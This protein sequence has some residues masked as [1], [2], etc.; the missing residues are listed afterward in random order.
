MK[1]FNQNLL[2][3]KLTCKEVSEKITV[4]FG[5]FCRNIAKKNR[6]LEV[7]DSRIKRNGNKKFFGNQ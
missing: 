3:W 4:I 7:L 1:E 5:T 2:L 6:E